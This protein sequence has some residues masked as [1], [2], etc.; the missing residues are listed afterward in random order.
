[1]AGLAVVVSAGKDPTTLSK[2]GDDPFVITVGAAHVHG[3]AATGDDAL[4]PFSRRSGGKPHVVAPRVSPRSPR[5]P[6]STIDGLNPTARVGDAYFKGSG[7][8]QAAAIVSGVLARMFQADPTLTPDE[9]KAALVATANPT[10]AGPGA[11][12][13]LIDANAAIA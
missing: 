6:G 3:T 12:A 10:L 9:A 5:A 1:Q 2:P 7:T 13:G 4:A 11:G 8:S